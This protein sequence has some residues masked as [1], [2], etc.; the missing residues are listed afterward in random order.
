MFYTINTLLYNAILFSFILES[1]P[2]LNKKQEESTEPSLI[3]PKQ[4][5]LIKHCTNNKLKIKEGQNNKKIKSSQLLFI[6][7]IIIV[8][9]GIWK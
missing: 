3:F 9:H 1:N 4:Y 7:I 5:Q 6:F 8:E 2:I